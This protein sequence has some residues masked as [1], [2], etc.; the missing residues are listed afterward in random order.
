MEEHN[1]TFTTILNNNFVPLYFL[2]SFFADKTYTFL[3]L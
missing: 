2:L 3:I 1:Q